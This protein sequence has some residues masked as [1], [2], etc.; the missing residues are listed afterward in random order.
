MRLKYEQ[1]ITQA[2]TATM[3]MKT[4]LKLAK[5]DQT[6]ETLTFDLE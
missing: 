1:H 5:E 6:V 3:Q 4:D 2:D